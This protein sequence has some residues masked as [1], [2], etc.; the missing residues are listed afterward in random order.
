MTHPQCVWSP[1]HIKADDVQAS[2]SFQFFIPADMQQTAYLRANDAMANTGRPRRAS[3]LRYVALCLPL[4]VASMALALIS[5]ADARALPHEGHHASAVISRA[6]AVS[7]PTADNFV[8]GS[9]IGQAPTTRNFN[10]VVSQLQGAPD[11]FSKS[12]LVVNG[13]CAS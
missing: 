13:T 5:G 11:G 8:V 10:F 2:S 7:V 3:G 6:D 12:M 9:I 1:K 4:M